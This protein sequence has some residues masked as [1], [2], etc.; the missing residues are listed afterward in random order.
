MHRFT[1]VALGCFFAVTGLSLAGV[2]PDFPY[3]ALVSSDQL[4]VRSGRGA[5]VLPNRPASSRSGGRGFFGTSQRLVRHSPARRQ[6]YLDFGPIL[7]ALAGRPGDGYRR[8]CV[9]PGGQRLQRH[10]R[11]SSRCGCTRAKWSR[12]WEPPHGAGQRA[13]AAGRDRPDDGPWFKIAPPSGEFRW[14]S[15][16]FLE[17]VRQEPERL[18]DDGQGHPAVPR[19]IPAAR[20]DSRADSPAP[21]VGAGKDSAGAGKDLVGAGKGSADAAGQRPRA[22]IGSAAHAFDGRVFRMNWI[23]ST[24]E[25]SVMVIEE[26]TGV[27]VRFAPRS[28]DE[29]QDQAAT[30]EE[31][32]GRNKSPTRFARFDDIQ[33]RQAA[34]LAMREQSVRNRSSLGVAIAAAEYG[35]GKGARRNL[36]PTGDLT[37][38]AGWRKCRRPS[39]APRTSR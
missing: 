5:G 32:S 23:E 7:E 12:C 1:A 9:G 39:R 26:P 21:P 14:V 3:K 20:A 35:A 28:T 33:R 22:P 4:Y 24:L 31:R 17:P 25:L 38:W 2:E 19:P 34:V 37:G 29:L 10:P 16:Q 36:R 30:S 11:L 18:R 13:T 15:A 27:V 8:G 6:L